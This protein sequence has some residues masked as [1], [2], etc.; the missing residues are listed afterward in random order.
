MDT[1][2]ISAREKGWKRFYWL[3]LQRLAGQFLKPNQILIETKYFTTIVKRPDD[4]R[5]R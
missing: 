2:F 5:R 1:T 4:K 3:N